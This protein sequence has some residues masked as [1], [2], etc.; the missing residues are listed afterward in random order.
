MG[1]RREAR[2]Y[3]RVVFVT[4]GI[5]RARHILGLALGCAR[6]RDRRLCYAAT[7]DE[8]LAET[9]ALRFPLFLDHLG[10]WQAL[11]NLHPSA[12]FER[13][14]VRINPSVQFPLPLFP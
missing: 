12:R 8:Y 9:D 4:T 3:F 2:P 7:L 1:N 6:N 10:R 11:V 14:A 13:S 5:E